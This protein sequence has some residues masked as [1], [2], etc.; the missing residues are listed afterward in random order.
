MFLE[1]DKLLGQFVRYFFVGGAAFIV[2]F[3][4]F[5]L[6]LY[7]F[8]VHYL[9]ANLI[10]LVVGLAVNYYMSVSWAFVGCGRILEKHKTSE[11]LVFSLIG[12]LGLLFNQLLMWLFI[13]VG[14]FIPWLSKM[15]AAVLVLI[16]N[17]GARKVMLFRKK[18]EI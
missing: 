5:A 16:W 11:F 12:I 4:L 2:D 18:K 13:G 3:S 14:N 8:H 7:V 9:V 17:F 1:K 15:A 10:G 6:F